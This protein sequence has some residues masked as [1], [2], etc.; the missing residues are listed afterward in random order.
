MFDSHCHLNF[1]VFSETYDKVIASAKARGVTHIMIPGTDIET[2]KKAILITQ[3]YLNLFAS[4][5]IHPTKDLE[6]IDL[7]KTMYILA[8]L[9]ANAKVKAI[10]EIGLDYYHYR[11]P[12]KIQKLFFLAQIK[13]A[14]KLEK[15]V[16]VHNRHAGDDLLKVLDDIWQDYFEKK[17]VFHCCEVNYAVLSFATTKK[18]F[19]G[20][21]GDVTY[22]K[23]KQEFIQ[24]VPLESLVIETDSPYITP[25]PFRSQKVFPNEPKNIVFIAQ[26]V[27]EIKKVSL[28][29]VISHTTK[30][31]CD[32]FQLT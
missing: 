26:K 9:L 31:A 25:E 15:S 12:S 8:E 2:S 3:D 4:V 7:D 6:A 1:Q 11:S 20:V 21:D 24:K 30:N 18:V 29:T 10:G 17:M 16:I 23:T 22:D 28:E 19:I 5:G 27:A 13:L 32:L 14:L